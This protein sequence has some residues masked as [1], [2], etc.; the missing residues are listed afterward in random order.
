MSFKVSND[1]KESINQA[2]KK[3]NKKRRIIRNQPEERD[4][5]HI[6]RNKP[7]I[8]LESIEQTEKEWEA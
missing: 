6:I 3:K 1:L 7:Q 5:Q 4:H 8:E 2:V